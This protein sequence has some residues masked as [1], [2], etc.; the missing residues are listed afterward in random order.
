MAGRGDD[1]VKYYV[2]ALGMRPDAATAE[3]GLR[4]TIAKT[5][6]PAP[7]ILQ[8][9]DVFRDLGRRL[10]S[11]D[12]SADTLK[13]A[14]QAAEWFPQSTQAR[15]YLGN[16]EMVHGD[17]EKAERLLRQVAQEE[18]ANVS[19]LLNLAQALRRMGRADE[20]AAALQGAL[21]LEP[22]NAF[23]KSELASMGR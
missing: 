14:R 16:L 15:F 19:A 6:Q 11:R 12:Y 17:L 13:K 21:R 18:P 22:N 4:A 2:K 10:G 7:E 1:A 23:A 20:A 9:L 8:R 3:R 5:G